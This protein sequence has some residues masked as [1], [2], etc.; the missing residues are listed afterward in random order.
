MLTA[1]ELGEA[2][3]K[4]L[5]RRTF[6]LEQLAERAGATQG[7]V[8]DT[9]NEM[10]TAGANL[11][12]FGDLWSLERRPASSVQK[13]RAFEYRS[14]PDG[15]YKFGLCADKHL[16]SKYERLDVMESL[17]A[18]FAAEG[19]DR[20]FDCGNW[21]DGECRLNRFDLNIHGLEPQIDYA[22]E[23]IPQHPGL[24]TY[25][26]HGDD[27]EGWFGQNESIDIGRFMEHKMRAAGRED[28]IDMGFMEA[29]VSLVHAKTGV[30]SKMLVMHPGG[31]SS[32]A[33][34]YKAQKLVESFQGGEK[35]AVALFGHYHKLNVF[36]VRNVWA[37]M[38]G[39]CQDQTPFL[40]KRSIEPVVGGAIVTMRQDEQTGA[41][42]SF[43]PDMRQ[44]FVKGYYNDR[45]TKVGRAVMPART[46]AGL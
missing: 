24:K 14:R 5:K 6:K 39:C 33:Q 3:Q 44:Y 19:V 22:V 35:P 2:L 45:W 37:M 32:Y 4:L 15:T 38:V 13:G 31:G 28:W 18:W 40:R 21:I 23:R 1:D 11:T 8:L 16:G 29:F 20:V 41:I 17:Y 10:Q 46:V 26:V 7:R 43:L 36:M 27:H 30:D 9:L 34:S 25:S 42:L 12:R